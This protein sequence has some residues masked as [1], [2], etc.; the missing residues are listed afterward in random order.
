MIIIKFCLF[1]HEFQFNFDKVCLFVFYYQ[2]KIFRGQVPS[3]FCLIEIFANEFIIISLPMTVM[4]M[5][6]HYNKFVWLV[7]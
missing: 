7:G 6:L 4:K 3:S 5:S 2:C 1:N